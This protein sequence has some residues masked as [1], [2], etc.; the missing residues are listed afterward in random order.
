MLFGFTNFSQA[1]HQF[2]FTSRSIVA[3]NYAFVSRF[4]QLA[5]STHHFHLGYLD[6]FTQ[7]CCSSITY[8]RVEVRFPCTIP[9][10][11]FLVRSYALPS[12]F[13]ICHLYNL[14][15]IVNLIRSLQFYLNELHLS[16]YILLINI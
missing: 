7:K 10:C 12:R 15:L 3:M 9:Y 13:N 16:R 6:L 14:T 5:D 2:A 1:T 11:F 8:R 4:V